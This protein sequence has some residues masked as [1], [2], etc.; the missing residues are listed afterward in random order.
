MTPN[1]EFERRL[2]FARAAANEAGRLI[3]SY[4]QSAHLAVDRKRDSSPVTAA[5]REAEQLIRGGIKREFPS[6]GILGEEFGETPGTS[7]FR[8]VLDPVDGTKSF[9]HGVP[10][11]GT[12]IGLEYQQKCV[13]G[14]CHLPT[15]GETAWGGRGLGAWWQPAGGDVRPARVSQVENLKDSLFCF[16]TVQGFARIGRQDAFEALVAGTGLARGCGDCYGHMLVATGRAEI[17][18][19]PLMNVW[20]A[21]ALVPIIEEAGGHFIDWNGAASANSGNGISVNALLREKVLA[22]TKR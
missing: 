13:V 19:D 4:Y 8:W 11:F 17:M 5:D 7:G 3:L 9:I 18:V 21:V 22:I 15:L 14:V 12:L 2:T 6:D 20:D 10:L 1:P 16:T